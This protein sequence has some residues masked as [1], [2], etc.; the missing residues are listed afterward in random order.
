MASP[1]KLSIVVFSGTPE[2]IH[3]AVAMASAAAATGKAV[4]LFFTMD[5]IKGLLAEGKPERPDWTTFDTDLAGKGLGTFAELSAACVEM[6]VTFMVCE[7]GLRAIGVEM[8]ELRDDIAFREGGIVTF[9][10]DASADGAML[11][12]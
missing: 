2:K 6:D 5:G 9:L 12:V 3:Y 7:M 4:T 8:S 1:D 10:S 11:F